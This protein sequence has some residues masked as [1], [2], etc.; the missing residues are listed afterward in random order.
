MADT[1]VDKILVPLMGDFAKARDLTGF[2]NQWYEQLVEFDHILSDRSSKYDLGH[3]GAWEDD[4]LFKKL[5]EI[6]EA[7]LTS[8]QIKSILDGIR[9]KTGNPGPAL[10]MMDAVVGALTREESVD[11]AELPLWAYSWLTTHKDVP[12]RYKLRQPQILTHI[13]DATSQTTFQ[14]QWG[15]DADMNKHVANADVV[16]K[17][18]NT[19]VEL[20]RS[21]ASKHT[22]LS[23]VNKHSA[24]EKLL[25][26]MVEVT[27]S[28]FAA[29]AIPW[30][31][32]SGKGTKKKNSGGRP[33]AIKLQTPDTAFALAKKIGRAS[34][35]E[36][37]WRV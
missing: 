21:A 25:L 1:Y 36:R 4:A 14:K 8:E 24:N 15:S 32:S 13:M 18:S 35:R 28:F 16:V 37:V 17:S 3:F 20:F 5:K 22:L 19:L 29:D 11:A 2:I 33:I 23:L 12:E 34:C 6:M 9:E 31:A 26:A 10:V 27:Q 30:F 7:S